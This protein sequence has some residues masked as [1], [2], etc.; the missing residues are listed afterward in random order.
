MH[1]SRRLSRRPHAR[2]EACRHRAQPVS[3]R[4]PLRRAGTGKEAWQPRR[5]SANP[6]PGPSPARSCWA[7]RPCRVSAAGRSRLE[8]RRRGLCWSSPWKSR[9]THLM[10]FH[11]PSPLL[12]GARHTGTPM[13]TFWFRVHSFVCC[14]HNGIQLIF[15]GRFPVE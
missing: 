3:P 1:R 10:S 9:C 2:G 14:Q 7:G 15:I 12:T 8:I 4:C 6:Q 11:S 13:D 5:G